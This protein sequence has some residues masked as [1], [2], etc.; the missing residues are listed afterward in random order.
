MMSIYD[1]TFVN[2]SGNR[3]T[4]ASYDAEYQ[5]VETDKFGD[6]GILIRWCYDDICKL[7]RNRVLILNLCRVDLSQI[8]QLTYRFAGAVLQSHD[9][10]IDVISLLD[11]MP[12]GCCI[13]IYKSIQLSLPYDYIFEHYHG[14]GYIIEVRSNGILMQRDRYLIK[15]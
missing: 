6:A 10:V 8:I 13:T 1:L 7:T 5:P 12:M 11:Q 4:R 9:A 14:N 3:Q 15:N 2:S